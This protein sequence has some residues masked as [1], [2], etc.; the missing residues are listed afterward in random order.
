M[1]GAAL[2]RSMVAAM[3]QMIR[4]RHRLVNAVRLPQKSAARAKRKD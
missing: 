3:I 2:T 4:E 1:A